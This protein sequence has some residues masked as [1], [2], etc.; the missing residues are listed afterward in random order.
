MSV[1]SQQRWERRMWKRW[2]REKPWVRWNT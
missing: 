1:V 2:L